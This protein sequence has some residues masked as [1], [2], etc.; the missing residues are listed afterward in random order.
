MNVREQIDVLDAAI[1]RHIRAARIAAGL[2]QDKLA[3]AID[4]S[5]GQLGRYESGLRHPR[6]GEVAKLAEHLGY[7]LEALITLC[8]TCANRPPGGFTCNQ[9][10][11]TTLLVEYEI[12][13]SDATSNGT[14]PHTDDEIAETADRLTE[15]VEQLGNELD[16]LSP[17]DAPDWG[18]TVRALREEAGLSQRDL[19]EKAGVSPGTIY[20]V[21]NSYGGQR[22]ST[23]KKIDRALTKIKL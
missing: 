5:V 12:D 15:Q 19:A 20:N 3:Q 7:D 9:C 16:Q 14:S 18:A 2:S 6:Y 13:V 11:D 4:V 17:V 22:V 10:G 8:P 1:G 23:R 21:E